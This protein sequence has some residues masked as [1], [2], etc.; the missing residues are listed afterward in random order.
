MR[1]RCVKNSIASIEGTSARER[2]QRSINLDGPINDLTVRRD[3]GVQALEER[4]GGLWFYLHTVPVSDYPY[5]YPAELFELLDNSIPEGW[6]IGFQDQPERGAVA[7]KRISFSAWANSDHFY[8][9]LV[10][11]E[12]IA[13]ALYQRMKA[14][15]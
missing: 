13:V 10:E 15:P 2:I 8:E 3:Y 4:D 1:V 12:A 6:G 5:P 14:K 7:W 11:G 9:R